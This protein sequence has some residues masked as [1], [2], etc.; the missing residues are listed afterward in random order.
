MI[1]RSR[2]RA[3]R[4][5]RREFVYLDEVSV[6]SLVAARDGSIAETVKD[7]LTQSSEV[8]SK[9][10]LGLSFKSAKLGTESRVRGTDTSAREVVRR[11]VIQSTFRDLRT[12]GENDIHLA[13]DGKRIR[14]F[15]PQKIRNIQELKRAKRKLSKN[16]YLLCA[17]EMKR[18]EVL[19]LELEI[20]ADKTYRLV[21]GISSIMEI[22]K[23]R[24]SLFGFDDTVYEQ[25]VPIVEI[26][27]RLLIGLVPI[28]GVS[29]RFGVVE[30]DGSDWIVD[31]NLL[32]A[33]SEITQIL[34]PLEVVGVT[35][36]RSYSK[37]LRRILF[38][39]A[40]YTAYMRI[41]SPA[42]SDDWNPVKLADV[43][44]GM[45]VDIGSLIDEL[46]D[47]FETALSQ[48]ASPS[49]DSLDFNEH[50]FAFGRRL[51][52][53][54]NIEFDPA[55]I[56]SATAAGILVVDLE[57]VDVRRRTFD[58]VANAIDPTADREV[59]RRLREEATANIVS[60]LECRNSLSSLPPPDRVKDLGR[61]LEVEFV[62]I[63]W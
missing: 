38:N 21:S 35:D 41:E 2:D 16:G 24:E 33:Q 53:E 30:V 42:L 56:A 18:G 34:R 1:F 49:Q 59:V 32:G 8:E 44:R 22:V 17:D 14:K 10:T 4:K 36:F 37:D 45:S 62:A 6:T 13:R 63:Y 11:S 60:A 15:R 57:D 55:K 51:A 39:D 12:G 52:D 19:E 40:I 43:L 48:P 47:S 31:R 20:R 25:V 3:W 29:T 23:G 9:S 54:L 26:I 61:K 27:D 28:R 58:I 5:Q 50:L 46:P 7:T